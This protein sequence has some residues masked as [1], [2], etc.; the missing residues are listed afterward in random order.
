VKTLRDIESARRVLRLWR[1]RAS[2]VA[3]VPT[4]GNLH[5]GH[6]SLITLARARA[7]RVVASIFVN[8]TQFGPTEDFA[9]YP[10]TLAADERALRGAGADA[11][12]VPTVAEMYPGGEASSTTVSVPP[13]ARQLCGAFRPGHFDGVSS[14]VLRLFNIVTPDVAVFGEKDYQQLVLLRRMTRD[15]H[16]PIRLV[17]AP[18]VREKDGLALSSRNQYLTADERRKAPELFAT[19]MACRERLL[20]GDHDFAALER[21]ALRRLRQCGF[22]PDYVAIRNAADLGAPA[23]RGPAELRVLAAA[24]L[25]R[26]RLIDN[27]SVRRR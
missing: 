9:R 21:Q 12:F 8:P 7:E 15:L 24:W 23:A 5:E 2:R 17:G 22:R 4:M 10:R 6:V 26:A 3:L 13:F 19:L 20:G 16:L 1:R 14:V 25:G 18:T 27:V 11:V